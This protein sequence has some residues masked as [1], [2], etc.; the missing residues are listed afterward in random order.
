MHLQM[1]HKMSASDLL[2]SASEIQVVC[3]R[4]AYWKTRKHLSP[5]PWMFYA[6]LKTDHSGTKS[7]VCHNGLNHTVGKM[8][9]SKTLLVFTITSK[10]ALTP[11]FHPVFHCWFITLH[12]HDR[13]A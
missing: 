12:I 7:T 2:S 8:T 13:Q 6:I 3:S 5:N 4:S 10:M 1:S 9:Q 11:H